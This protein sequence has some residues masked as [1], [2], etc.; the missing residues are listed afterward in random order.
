[1]ILLANFL[2]S[3]TKGPVSS[4]FRCKTRAAKSRMADDPAQASNHSSVQMPSAPVINHVFFL[5]ISV[6][7]AVIIHNASHKHMV[8]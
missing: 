6:S 8:A 3:K 1:M 4:E 2:C 7:F 5:L